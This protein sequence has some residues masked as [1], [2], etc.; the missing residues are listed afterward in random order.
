MDYFPNIDAVQYFCNAIFPLLRKAMPE[1]RFSIVGRHPTQRVKAL[2]RYPNVTVTGTV[3]DVRPYLSKAMVAVAPL[4]IA[5][6]VQN[7]ILEAMAMGLPVVG[8]SQAFQ[9]LHV[10]TGDGVRTA[11][12]PEEFAQEVFTLL[13]DHTLQHQCSLQARYYV[14]C[15]HHWQ[16]HGVHLDSILQE[17][18]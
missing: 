17:M 10:S 12:T 15:Y 13:K 6:G 9:G 3:P 7:K 4:R 5:R 18:D 2:G 11:D 14:Q 8:T 16:D 1:A